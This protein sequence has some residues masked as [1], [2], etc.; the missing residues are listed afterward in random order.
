MPTFGDFETVG[1]PFD[2]S[3]ENGVVS[4]W[5][6]AQNPIRPGRLYAIKCVSA[7]RRSEQEL[8]ETVEQLKT[9]QARDPAN[10]APVHGFGTSEEGVWYATDFC[11][12]GSLKSWIM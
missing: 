6:K 9:A 3:D 7:G 8:L 10:L 5:W 12:R 2:V 11:R 1:D 4:T